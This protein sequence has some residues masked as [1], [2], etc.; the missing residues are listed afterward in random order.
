MSE[1]AGRP[2]THDDF[3]LDTAEA[4]ELF[5]GYAEGCPVIDFHCHLPP[6]ELAADQRWENLTQVWLY[7]DHYK[8]RAMRSNGVAEELVTGPAG[9]RERFDAWAATMPYL[10]RNPLYHWT[11]LELARY[12]GV[13]DL[14]SPATADAV[15]ERGVERLSERGMSARGLVT[16][17]E[18][19][20]ICT[21][22]D[23][24]DPLDHH[25][26]L[27]GDASFP[28][29]VLPTWRPDKALNAG[30]AE[31]FNAW[32]ERLEQA[33]GVGAGT[34]DGFME[35]LAKRHDDFAAAGCRLADHGVETFHAAPFTL[36]GL[37]DTYAAVRGGRA[38]VGD[39]L[40]AWRSGLLYELAR[41]N[42]AKGWA[43][44][45][46]FGAMRNNNSRMFQKLGP[47]AGFDS[48]GDRDHGAAM[49]GF[50]DRLDARGELAKTVLYNIHP[51]D[52]LL[53]ASMLGNFQD[54][55]VPGKMQM[56]SGWWFLDTLGGMERQLEDLSN[57]GLLSRFVGMLTDSRSFLSYTRHE[58]FRRVLCNVL[59]GEMARGLLPRDFGLV[60]G[61]V[62]DI[63]HRN[64]ARYFGFD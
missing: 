61:M 64:A 54:G 33:S 50:L 63:C 6:A 60:G 24:A 43:Q 3:L 41:M 4:R 48:I 59:G 26:A 22:D 20:V 55:S 51:K 31:A 18:V 1:S 37:R 28:V 19:R 16:R 49:A 34:F 17:S 27:A 15:W 40:E 44:Q 2:F 23:P 9:D 12:F 5:H 30:D 25:L 47:D 36:A 32:S 35:A 45:F 52:N 7:G 10:L 53:V 29:R 8:W 56:G 38:A 39:E 62:E 11:H 42:H 46:H 13:A 57:L 21:T 58:Y 14:L